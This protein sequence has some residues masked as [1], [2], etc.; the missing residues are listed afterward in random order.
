VTP[1]GHP[2][3]EGFSLIEA[4]VALLIL[5]IAAAGLVR[6]V[7]SHIDSIGGLEQRAAA[8]WVAENALAELALANGAA[9]RQGAPVAMLGRMWQVDVRTRA[10]D[11]PD[12]RRVDVGVRPVGSISSLVTLSGFVDRDRPAIAAPSGMAQR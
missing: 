7:E 4:L 9:E 6:A 10:S 2:Q 1:P 5:G 3:E 11:D 8:L 12:L